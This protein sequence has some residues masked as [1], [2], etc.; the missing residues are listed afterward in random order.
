MGAPNTPVT[1]YSSL[2]SITEPQSTSNRAVLRSAAPLTSAQ[3]PLTST[4]F[5]LTS[6]MRSQPRQWEAVESLQ[7]FTETV[8]RVLAEYRQGPLLHTFGESLSAPRR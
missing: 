7:M 3:F 6:T 4:R 2:T 8:E 1:R 5:P